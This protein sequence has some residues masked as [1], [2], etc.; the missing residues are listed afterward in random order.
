MP[1]DRPRQVQ[2][3]AFTPRIIVTV[4]PPRDGERRA[5]WS[6][7]GTGK[8]ALPLVD[9]S[10]SVQQKL[11]GQPV[12]A[13][14]E[15]VFTADATP[16]TLEIKPGAEVVLPQQAQVPGAPA[17]AVAEEEAG[18]PSNFD[19]NPYN[20]AE[21]EGEAP[22]LPAA[23]AHDHA[24]HDRYWS[25]RK[26]GVI[27]VTYEAKT[28]IMIPQGLTRWA[29]GDAKDDRPRHFWKCYDAQGVEKYGI[30]GSSIKGT[31]R[32][33]FE[34]WT[35]SRMGQVTQKLYD[36]PI[37][38]RRRS[39]QGYVVTSMTNGL[40]VKR[41]EKG[42]VFAR[43]VG[44][45]WF[46]KDGGWV[47]LI[48]NAPVV[49]VSSINPNNTGE[50]QAVPE[51]R[52]NLLWTPDWID[53]GVRKGN[54]TE[55]YTHLIVRVGTAVATVDQATV[56][57][58]K[59]SFSHDAYKNHPK[60]VAAI[61]VGPGPHDFYN[62]VLGENVAGRVAEI[63]DLQVGDLLFGI[64]EPMGTLACFGRNVNF[65]WPS[66][67]APGDLAKSF[68]PMP[69]DQAALPVADH[70]EATFGFAGKLA[71]Q[72]H[73]FRGRTR[74]TTFW[75]TNSAEPMAAQ[76][77][78]ALTSPTGVKL[79]SRPTYLPRRADGKA[80]TYDEASKLRGRKL[81][82]HQ[83]TP[84]GSL[85]HTL[86][87]GTAAQNLEQLP[88]PLHPLPR[89]ATFAGQVHFDN[90]SAAELGALLVSLNPELMFSAEGE[91]EYGIKVGKGKPRGLGSLRC[92]AT[93]V[94]VRRAGADAYAD[95]TGDVLTEATS[96]SEFVQDFKVELAK[97]AGMDPMQVTFIRDLRSLLRLRSEPRD[98]V[99]APGDYGW[100]SDLMLP[101]LNQPGNAR[102]VG[103][104]KGDP[105]PQ[106]S[107]PI[108]MK[109]ARFL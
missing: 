33:L 15:C 45:G 14:I 8:G 86:P 27:D 94:R 104:A 42:V 49:E 108:G 61:P 39:V 93:S 12:G 46:V 56:D 30:P 101:H 57:R 19:S 69:D 6:I 38:Y 32:S 107:R 18:P 52:L 99:Q 43:K 63:T 60:R 79:K 16:A 74:F 10:E 68:L 83:V 51:P 106:D 102:R 3:Q 78:K 28:P 88:P 85:A 41:C 34:I 22:W 23:G 47:P 55:P 64:E 98:Y 5:G 80:A 48:A 54:L 37:P 59:R 70:A 1:F 62:N 72:S 109:R 66:T 21:W 40:T 91:Q 105:R 31:I 35:N 65:L 53:H 25:D 103:A 75:Q 67:N 96:G 82:W 11:A 100:P 97:R 2:R 81:Y 26:S 89:G 73:P 84:D 7:G 24:T 58:W 71:G 36:N 76:R 44:T 20:F 87:A 77:L 90:L 13:K 95:L 29:G 92:T 50:W 4:T 9:Y 17:A